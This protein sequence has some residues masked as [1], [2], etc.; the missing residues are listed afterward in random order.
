MPQFDTHF[1]TSLVFWSIVSFAILLFLLYK[2][3]L[4]PILQTLEAR[5]RRI[6]E[7]LDKAERLRQEAERHLAEAE[8]RL[9]QA[10]ASAE[11][12]VRL[13]HE[14]G[15]RTAMEH[16]RHILEQTEK[17]LAEAREGIERARKR[18]VQEIRAQAVEISLLAAE[19]LLERNLRDEE[20]LRL[21]RETIDAV[22]EREKQ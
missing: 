22:V 6:R 3:A 15:E 21:V 7:D 13:A 5:E 14:R 12:I 19:K 1:L 9:K 8:A 18:A 4:P 11:E 10:H 16:Q 17:M 20:N 2:F